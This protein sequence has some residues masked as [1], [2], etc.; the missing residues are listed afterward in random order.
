LAGLSDAGAAGG[1]VASVWLN[2]F[3]TVGTERHSENCLARLF[4][5]DEGGRLLLLPETRLPVNHV[6]VHWE[7]LLFEPSEFASRS[8]NWA[9]CFALG[10]VPFDLKKSCHCLGISTLSLSSLS[11]YPLQDS[12]LSSDNDCLSLPAKTLHFLLQVQLK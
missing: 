3:A 5:A 8:M 12:G 9:L 4:E 2:L 7:G 11:S 1:A 6:G 10:L